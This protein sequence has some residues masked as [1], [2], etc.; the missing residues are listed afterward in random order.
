MEKRNSVIELK[1]N[2][3]KYM[4]NLPLYIAKK[5]ENSFTYKLISQKSSFNQWS[6]NIDGYDKTI[7]IILRIN[8]NRLYINLKCQYVN[9]FSFKIINEELKSIQNLENIIKEILPVI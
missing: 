1:H 3:V 6:C 2:C 9:V 7:D 8:N 4:R 5:H